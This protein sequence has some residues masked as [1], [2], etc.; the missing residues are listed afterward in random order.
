MPYYGTMQPVA[1]VR[2]QEQPIGDMLLGL[3]LSGAV[4]DVKSPAMRKK[5]GAG[6]SEIL[7]MLAAMGQNGGAPVPPGMV[8]PG[9]GNVDPTMGDLRP[10]VDPGFTGLPPGTMQPGGRSGILEA[11]L[12]RLNPNRPTQMGGGM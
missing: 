3:G 12:R 9:M 6:S 7:K 4:G 10:V 1:P 11:L 8:Q 2:S 5:A